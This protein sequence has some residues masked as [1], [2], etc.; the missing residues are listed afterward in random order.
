M[1]E[2]IGNLRVR[3]ASFYGYRPGNPSRSPSD[4]D[5]RI[6]GSDAEFEISERANELKDSGTITVSNHMGEHTGKFDHGDRLELWVEDETVF[7]EGDAYGHT[8][9]G[10]GTYSST[11]QQAWVGYVRPTGVE[12]KGAGNYALTA[13][14]EDF[15][16]AILGTR[17]YYQSHENEDPGSILRSAL[18][19][20][21]TELDTSKI[22]DVGTTITV[23]SNGRYLLDVLKECMSKGGAVAHADGTSLVFRPSESLTEQFRA[24][25]STKDYREESYESNDDGLVNR[26]RVKGGPSPQE[27]D[28]LD[29]FDH[30]V[31]VDD[32]TYAS[33]QITTGKPT[34]SEV[35]IYAEST[36]E[37]NITV[38]IQEDNGGSPEDPMNDKADLV[39]RQVSGEFLGNGGFVTVDLNDN[40]FFRGSP[41]VVIRGTGTSGQKIGVDV[42]GVALYV[43]YY[44]YPTNVQ[45]T[46]PDSIDDYRRR[47]EKLVDSTIR[48]TSEAAETG[49]SRLDHK[50]TPSEKLSFAAN[51]RRAHSLQVG[52]AFHVDDEKLGTDTT[53]VVTKRD[54]TF[55][56]T[57]L[58][59]GVEAQ[60]L[61]SL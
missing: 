57:R 48:G 41:H 6:P 27:T 3:E 1:P 45:V 30:Y 19:A 2:A 40:H 16:Y 5:Y 29:T 33:A 44:P 31:T 47:D 22:D 18:A 60:S 34:I 11:S 46:E 39:G 13:T 54:S 32:S 36:G 14:V 55:G 52:D 58:R 12:A 4:A 21:A 20:E 28:R 7:P 26:L 15:V 42:N 50:G 10:G 35:E 8:V 43:A 51:T 37:E 53:Y 56:G 38:A 9:Y 24:T 25:W 59:R 17:R 23:R 61:D 49:N